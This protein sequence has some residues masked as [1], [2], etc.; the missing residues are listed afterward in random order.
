MQ[1][2]RTNYEEFLIDYLDQK[3]GP[4]EVAELLLFLEQNPDIK[5][6]FEKLSES[7]VIQVET[8]VYPFKEQLK[9]PVDFKEKQDNY[10]QNLLLNFIENNI[11]DSD[12]TI[13][14]ERIKKDADFKQELYLFTQTKLEPENNL[15][16]PEKHKLKK[17]NKLIS[18]L[19]YSISAAAA[20][21]IFF[22]TFSF[23]YQKVQPTAH[24][25]KLEP[26]TLPVKLK[27]K[28]ASNKHETVIKTANPTSIFEKS[29]N[30]SNELNTLPKAHISEIELQPIF[31]NKIDNLV[32]NTQPVAK[33]TETET[34]LLTTI[35]PSLN[36]E[37][38]L[39]E[40]KYLSLNEL[41]Q[42]KLKKITRGNVSNES[43]ENKDK[44]N[45]K[46]SKWD[47][48]ALSAK[49]IS[50]LSGNTIEVKNDYNEQG[51]LKQFAIISKDFEFSKSR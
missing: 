22:F 43:L 14:E 34:E 50:K 11:S 13:V 44:R 36:L 24:T 28:V 40:K 26:T 47:L 1:I 8:L 16:Y 48:A 30:T 3:L 41:L 10:V 33:N 23:F 49:V 51:Q 46:L 5:S 20:V 38:Q 18:L 31:V 27:Q 29:K 21:L 12:K 25:H 2:D 35:P 7:S 9:Q 39:E 32:Q 42:T 19:Y 15:V 4:V 37:T 17:S 45:D 6:E